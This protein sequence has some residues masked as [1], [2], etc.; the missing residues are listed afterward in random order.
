MPKPV[1]NQL[2]QPVLLN[3]RIPSKS[4]NTAGLSMEA[5]NPS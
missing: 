1:L 2:S 3:Y 5:C 4:K